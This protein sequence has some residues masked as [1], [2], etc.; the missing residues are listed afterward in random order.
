[1]QT[2]FFVIFGS[3]KKYDFFFAKWTLLAII[4]KKMF[5]YGPK[6][7]FFAINEFFGPHPKINKNTVL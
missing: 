7:S 5:G 3:P 1:M 4:K 2:F 6:N